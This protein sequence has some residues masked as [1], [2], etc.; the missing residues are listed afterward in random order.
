MSDMP[1]DEQLLAGQAETLDL[2]NTEVTASLAQQADVSARYESKALALVGYAGALSAFLATR[3][4]QPVLATLAYVAYGLAA[5]FG[6]VVFVVA[7]GLTSLA[8]PRELFNNYVRR[9]KARTL[10]ALGATRVRVY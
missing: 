7:S 8:A 1:S 4:A 9:S 3:H 10:A 6:I 2:I 5:S